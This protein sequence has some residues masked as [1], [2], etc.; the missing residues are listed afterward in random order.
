MALD[1]RTR[2]GL[3]MP[4][5]ELT[6]VTGA[7][8]HQGGAVARALLARGQRV[9][10]F[11]RDPESP[12]A[13]ALDRL[14]AELV[15]GDFN[16]RP[17]LE[18]AAAGATAIFSMQTPLLHDLQGDAE[19]VAAEN[20]VAAARAAGVM[21]LVHTSVAGADDPGY[22]DPT[23]KYWQDKA[24]ANELVRASGVLHWTIVKPAF[25]MENFVRPSP[26]FAGFTSDRLLT[27][28]LPAT[29]LALIAC[30]DIGTAVAA[31]IAD[32]ARF[33][34]VELELAGDRLTMR[35]IARV[36]SDVLG[37][38]VE[39]PTLSPEEAI[40]QGLA[41][42]FAWPHARLNHVENPAH[43]RLAHALGLPTTS[44]ATWAHRHL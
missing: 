37:V 24:Y 44:F 40:A 11:V 27:T 30:D 29:E 3:D 21:H 8:G 38:P 14:G 19:R 15:R 41:P 10:A 28:I 42:A 32:P 5:T 23:V 18:R 1:E 2:D 33:D 16:D 9:R 7:T 36:L 31:A 25:F 39:A 13:A 43:P 4:T 12:A 17:S 6:L 22:A 34:R 26:M 35:E 20:I